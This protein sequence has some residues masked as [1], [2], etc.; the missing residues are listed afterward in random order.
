[1]LH[2]KALK[3]DLSNFLNS[4]SKGWPCWQFPHWLCEVTSLQ[5]FISRKLLNVTKCW[6]WLFFTNVFYFW[7][8]SIDC[9]TSLKLFGN[10]WMSPNVD[11][12]NFHKVHNV[13]HDLHFC[14][15]LHFPLNNFYIPPPPPKG[16]D[17][18]WPTFLEILENTICCEYLYDENIDGGWNSIEIKF[19]SIEI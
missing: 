15:L 10:F 9:V 2:L 16:I 13:S 4:L 6:S 14:Q 7:F 1:M 18:N 3:P 8:S 11:L 12:D 5:L 17:R 19:N